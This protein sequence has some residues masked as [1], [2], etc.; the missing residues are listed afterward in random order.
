MADQKDAKGK[1]P[2]SRF[3]KVRGLVQALV[4]DFS[5]YSSKRGRYSYNASFG[6][7][8][9]FSG[10]I[11][12]PITKSIGATGSNMPDR[13]KTVLKWTQVIEATAVPSFRYVIRGNSVFDPGFTSGSTQPAGYQAFS[14]QYGYYR[15]HWSKIK[16]SYNNVGA[17]ATVP[18]LATLYP[19][20]LSNPFTAT[21]NSTGQARYSSSQIFANGSS[22]GISQ[23]GAGGTANCLTNAMST[24]KV[25]GDL[26]DT[27]SV[28]G[29]A[30]GTNPAAPWF[31]VFD[32][33]TLDASSFTT[34][35]YFYIEVLFGVDFESPTQVLG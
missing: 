6:Q 25:F 31:W 1:V 28:Y 11:G 17:T 7:S 13:L 33:L 16:I 8:R 35:S 2:P 15:V 30:N 3:G 34:T 22:G 26:Q 4:Y 14:L 10:N 5:G 21:L 12:R 32:C 29:A 27:E 23:Y 18:F 9:G 24:K 20:T 19:S